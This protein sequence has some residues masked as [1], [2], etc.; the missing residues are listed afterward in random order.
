[1]LFATAL[2]NPV[3]MK[4]KA[5]PTSVVELLTVISPS[6]ISIVPLTEQLLHFTVAESLNEPT[7]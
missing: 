6:T 3:F 2:K 4:S 1:M 7:L 5:C